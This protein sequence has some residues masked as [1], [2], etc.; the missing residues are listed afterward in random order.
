[1]VRTSPNGLLS[2][3]RGG[4]FGRRQPAR[5]IVAE[6]RA[7]YAVTP[8]EKQWLDSRIEAD[9]KLDPLEQ[10]LLAFLQEERGAKG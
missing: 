10:A 7:D 5:D 3:V 1:M 6:E 2:A 9:G 8:V 4:G